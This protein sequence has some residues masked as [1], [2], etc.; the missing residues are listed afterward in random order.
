MT[1][2]F[3]FS[4]SG[5]DIDSDV[6][7]APVLTASA[8]TPAKPISRQSAFPVEGKPQ[9]PPLHH[10]L[11]ALLASLPSKI[12]YDMLRIHLDDGRLVSLPRRELWDVRIQLMAEDE[13]FDGEVDRPGGAV[14][15]LG[16]HDVKTGVYEGGFKSW[17]SSVDLVKVLAA[18]GY[19]DKQRDRASRVVEVSLT[20]CEK[21]FDWA[22]VLSPPY[23]SQFYSWPCASL[24]Y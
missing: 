13:G 1:S 18:N 6:E 17:E 3:A 23:I 5:D 14:E 22:F 12:A 15:G 24:G 16:G 4:F 21:T 7:T 2:S 10:P 11:E 8:A 9:F 19:A 20:I